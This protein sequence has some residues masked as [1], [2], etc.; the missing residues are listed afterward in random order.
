ML[1]YTSNIGEPLAIVSD[2][3][4][5]YNIPVKYFFLNTKHICVQSFQDD[6]TNNLIESFNNRFKACYKTKCDFD[7]FQ[8]ANAAISVF[9]FF[10]N[11]IRPHVGL[12]QLTPAQVAGAIITPTLKICSH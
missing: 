8:S 1:S 6:I 9:I 4:Y 12:N 3:Y 11:F 7:S 5:S 10:F 2:R